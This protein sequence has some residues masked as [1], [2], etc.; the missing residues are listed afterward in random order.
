MNVI[1]YS[2]A[3]CLYPRAT[4]LDRV[5]LVLL[6]DFD[7]QDAVGAKYVARGWRFILDDLQKKK[8]FDPAFT[9]TMRRI[10]DKHSWVLP[11]NMGGVI[12]PAHL[13]R[14]MPCH[15]SVST[16]WQLVRRNAVYRGFF[17][18]EEIS[19]KVLKHDALWYTHV[20][21]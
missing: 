10:D 1:S 13:S 14:L 11:L 5:S 16:P 9:T 15:P 20:I 19:T 6:D 17:T 21:L 4:L 12:R 8:S 18:K 2:H 7:V 3:Y